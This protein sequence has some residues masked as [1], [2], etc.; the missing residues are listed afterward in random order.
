MIGIVNDRK[1]E[2]VYCRCD[3]LTNDEVDDGFRLEI[4]FATGKTA[5]VEVGTYNFIAM[6]RFYMQSK[7][8]SF[9]QK[10]WQTKP[11]IAHLTRW[12]E[13]DVTPVQNAAGITKT[14]APRD[15]LTLDIYE[16]DIPQSDV[17]NFYRN[18]CKAID[19]ETEQMIKNCEVRR[20]L[21]V[22]MAAFRSDEERQTIKVTI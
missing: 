3:H 22:M 10:D 1:I 21:S 20:V 15:E 16:N 5:L 2:K 11:Q 6:P 17:H 8:G 7:E 14:M 4:G 19:G 9:M 18:F 12:V 13:Q